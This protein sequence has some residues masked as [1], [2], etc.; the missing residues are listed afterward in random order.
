MSNGEEYKKVL[1]PGHAILNITVLEGSEDMK[2]NYNE[3]LFSPEE[4]LERKQKLLSW[5]KKNL[6]P[7][8]ESGENIV[9]GNVSILPPYCESDICTLNPIVATQVKKVILN[10]P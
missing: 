8:T 7:V 1:I 4:I 2:P 10:M 5:L 3:S 9:V 6:L